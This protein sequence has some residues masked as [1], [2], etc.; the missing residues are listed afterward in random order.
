MPPFLVVVRLS[1][2][3]NRTVVDLLGG[4]AEFVL[5]NRAQRCC[6]FAA[7]FLLPGWGISQSDQIAGSPVQLCQKRP[8]FSDRDV[9]T[10]LRE[11]PPHSRFAVDFAVNMWV[12]SHGTPTELS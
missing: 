12:M 6:F 1:A 7:E 8:R 11:D 5:S 4:F 10:D 2:N 3:L 9:M